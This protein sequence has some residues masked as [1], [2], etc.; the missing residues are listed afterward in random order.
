MVTILPP[1]IF[2]R[3]ATT[4]VKGWQVATGNRASC[5]WQQQ[6]LSIKAQSSNFHRAL[7]LDLQSYWISNSNWTEWST[8]QGVIAPVISKSDEREVQGRFQI[9]STITP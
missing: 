1:A 6:V 4:D 2:S 7:L 5:P 3:F 9:T 8:I